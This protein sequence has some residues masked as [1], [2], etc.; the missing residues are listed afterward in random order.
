MPLINARN[1]ESIKMG[2]TFY[3]MLSERELSFSEGSQ[4]SH[5][6]RTG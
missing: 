3:Q 4:T 2:N 5:I 1:V 6:C